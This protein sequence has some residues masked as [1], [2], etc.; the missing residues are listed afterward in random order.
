M[1]FN[2]LDFLQRKRKNMLGHQ[3]EFWYDHVD[4]NVSNTTAMVG[5]VVMVIL[6][7]LD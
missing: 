7:V 3:E 1:P 2:T 6:K 5:L 4:N